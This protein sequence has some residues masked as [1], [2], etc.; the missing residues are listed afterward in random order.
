MI[1][2]NLIFGSRVPRR[3]VI[4]ANDIY[5]ANTTGYSLRGK[6]VCKPEKHI[7]EDVTMY[8]PPY[9]MDRYSNISL[10]A[11][12]M[13]VHGVAFFMAI[14]RHIKHISVI[15]IQKRNYNTILGCIDQLKAA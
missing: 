13:Y 15:P 6:T 5:G 3:D 10:S 9:I 2:N 4:I 11:H 14:L 7:R 1:N 12:I 8:M